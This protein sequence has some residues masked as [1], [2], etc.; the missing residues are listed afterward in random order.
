MKASKVLLS[1]GEEVGEHITEDREEV[2]IILKG[3]GILIDG[4][5]RI[6]LK[7]GQA[8]HIKQDTRHNVKNISPMELEYI[9]V[10]S[11]SR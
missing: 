1:P 7:E 5:I 10:V 11:F 9:Y 6:P 8:H 3:E 2:I 4:G